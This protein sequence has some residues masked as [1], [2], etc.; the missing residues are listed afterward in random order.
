[1]AVEVEVAPPF[2]FRTKPLK[3][4]AADLAAAAAADETDEL[5]CCCSFLP[6]ATA[7]DVNEDEVSYPSLLLLT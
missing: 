2:F 3:S 6:L 1:M 7:E 4:F 5:L